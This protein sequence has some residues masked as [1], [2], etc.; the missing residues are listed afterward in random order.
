MAV[1]GSRGKAMDCRPDDR[2]SNY[3]GSSCTKE[4]MRAVAHPCIV[5]LRKDT[6]ID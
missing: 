3:N 5:W 4:K 2:Y 6:T 1:K